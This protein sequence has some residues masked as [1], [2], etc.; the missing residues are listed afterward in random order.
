M[1]LTNTFCSNN[2]RNGPLFLKVSLEFNCAPYK[3]T[4]GLLTLKVNPFGNG[5][6]CIIS[7]SL[8]HLHCFA[9]APQWN[10]VSLLELCAT[11]KVVIPQ[12]STL[13]NLFT[14]LPWSIQAKFFVTLFGKWYRAFVKKSNSSLFY[15]IWLSKLDISQLSRPKKSEKGIYNLFNFRR[16]MTISPFLYLFPF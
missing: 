13:G 9:N 6:M 15:K 16:E 10:D 2:C 11:F 1:F 5:W 8:H 7:S 4:M 3:V 12:T 14:F